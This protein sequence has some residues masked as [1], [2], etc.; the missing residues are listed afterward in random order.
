MDPGGHAEISGDNSG[1][2]RARRGCLYR[3]A[4]RGQHGQDARP[5]A[6]SLVDPFRCLR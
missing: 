5:A 3:H 4:A 6:V 2:H 1:R